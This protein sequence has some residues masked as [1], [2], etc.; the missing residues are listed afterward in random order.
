MTNADAK[1][2]FNIGSVPARSMLLLLLRGETWELPGTTYEEMQ[3]ALWIA[4]KKH[5]G[6]T[7]QM[8]VCYMNSISFANV[9]EFHQTNVLRGWN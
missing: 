9:P 2:P 3:S 8:H 4:T 5:F 6:Q 1:K 7:R